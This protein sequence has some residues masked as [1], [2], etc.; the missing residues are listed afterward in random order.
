[1]TR[2]PAG[3]APGARSGELARSVGLLGVQRVAVA[4]L[5]VVRTK[6]AASL[7]GPAGMGLLAQAITLQDLLRSLSTLGSPNGFLKL[8]AQHRGEGDFRELERLLVSAGA[9]YGGLSL[10]IAAACALAAK[11]IAGAV[12]DDPSRVD[13]VIAVALSLVFLVP[14]ILV[15]K[16]FAGLLDY[17]SYALLAM[18]ESLVWV[19]AMAVLATCFGLRGAV[20]SLPVVEAVALLVGGV[21]LVR[22]LRPLGL[23]LRSCRPSP[24]AL[25][26]LLRLASALAFTSLTATAATLFVRS[27]IVRS[28]G[29]SAN[30]HYQVAWQVGQNYLAFLGAALWSYGMP[31]VA[32]QLA[33]PEAVVATQNEFLRIA[34]LAFA[35]GI[36]L[37][38][39]TRAIWI[40]VLF[41]E[42]FLAAGS[43]LCWQLGGE[44]AAMLRQSMNISLLPRERLGFLV[45]QA[46]AYWALWASVSWVLLGRLGALAAAVGYFVAN[47]VMLV[48]T[49][50]YHR[51]VLG[52]HVAAPNR[53]LLASTLPMFAA[54]TAL[55]LWTDPLLG[56]VA[57]L[58]LV[59]LWALAHRAELRPLLTSLASRG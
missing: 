44:L 36:V 52:F 34:L 28:I 49:Y 12:F 51:R 22:R 46:L 15:L 57:P 39:A 5:G 37:L 14:G 13:L 26:R 31:R 58:A 30:G 47:A 6:I 21:M 55:S 2:E 54:G 33:D 59:A 43:M 53:R 4:A 41:T 48:A 25:R 56:A 38:L 29:S 50:G 7:L 16:I 18:G 19:V 24:P 3:P 1:V 40:P 9:L 27:E 20:W 45:V 10:A 8:V 23:D 42:E 32:S 17:R 35:P 11:P